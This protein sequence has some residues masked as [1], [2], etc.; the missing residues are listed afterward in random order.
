MVWVSKVLIVAL[1]VTS[2]AGFLLSS[3]HATNYKRVDRRCHQ[4]E[5]RQQRG[6]HFLLNRRQ[7]VHSLGRGI[8]R[9]ESE[10]VKINEELQPWCFGIIADVQYVDAENAMNFQQTHTRRYRQSLSIFHEAV[11]K[12]NSLAPNM[13]CAVLLGDLLD[14]KCNDH[15]NTGANL[16]YKS[17]KDLQRITSSSTQP[18][19]YCF[20]NHDYYS[21]DRNELLKYFIPQQH[22]REC[23]YEK[24]YYDWRPNG[25]TGWRFIC[26]DSYDVS[27][28]GYSSYEHEK[29]A[30][31]MLIKNNPND[32]SISGGWFKDLPDDKFRFVPYNGAVSYQQLRWL[33]SVLRRAQENNEK[34]ICFCHQPIYS[35]KLQSL[36]WN[37]EDILDVLH[38][39]GDTVQMWIAGHDHG[40]HYSVDAQ[41]IHHVVP[42]APLECEQGAKAYGF[43]EVREHELILNWT[44]STPRKSALSW[45]NRFKIRSSRDKHDT[46]LNTTDDITLV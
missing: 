17:L 41:G 37:S 27:L 45:P 2:C 1:F 28:I 8:E 12:W 35:T 42:P 32:L 20:G 36:V 40:G 30:K 9:E 7:R 18:L 14:G 33:K 6:S 29:Q 46:K 24:L 16:R 13:R 5:Q 26:I 15:V 23:S 19:H 43:I 10:Q 31:D 21:F 38:S 34:C 22:K 44:G 39:F 4:Q 25:T 3:L 11:H